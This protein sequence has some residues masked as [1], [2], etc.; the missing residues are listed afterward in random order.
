LVIEIDVGMLRTRRGWTRAERRNGI[1]VGVLFLTAIVA[2]LAGGI[3]IDGVLSGQDDIAGAGENQA[4]VATGVI[5]ELVNGV[6]VIG[7]AACMF[8]ILRKQSEALAVAYAA[9]RVI[10]AAVIVAAVVGPLAMV[11]LAQESVGTGAVDGPDL[12][13]VG[14]SLLAQRSVLVGLLTALFF[15]LAALLLYGLMY[16]AIL[17][18]RFIC[19]WGIVAVSLV[20]GWNLPEMFGISISFGIVLALPMILNEVFLAIW[21]IIKGFSLPAIAAETS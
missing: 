16:R 13:L 17:V 12:W 7:I 19:V 5:L 8:P 21:L 9:L 11:G 2:S 10:E 20:M 1:A 18:P 4:L 15:G 6:A 3:L 14:A